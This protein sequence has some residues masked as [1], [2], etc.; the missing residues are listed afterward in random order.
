[1]IPIAIFVYQRDPEG[2]RGYYLFRLLLPTFLEPRWKIPEILGIF[3]A[4]DHFGTYNSSATRSGA[5][6]GVTY[7]WNPPPRHH[8]MAWFEGNLHGKPW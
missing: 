6:D 2:S 4:P 3:G 7:D 1:M 5:G 8:A